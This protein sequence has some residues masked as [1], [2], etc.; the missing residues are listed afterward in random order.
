MS[1]MLYHLI[2]LLVND[3]D[4]SIKDISISKYNLV[5]YILDLFG[6]RSLTGM[7]LGLKTF[8]WRKNCY[9]FQNSVEPIFFEDKCKSHLNIWWRGNIAKWKVKRLFFFFIVSTIPGDI[10]F[11]VRFNHKNGRLKYMKLNNFFHVWII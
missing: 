3:K 10:M 6:R 2:K 9:E 11:Y 7:Y 8:F 4:K 5:F 1:K